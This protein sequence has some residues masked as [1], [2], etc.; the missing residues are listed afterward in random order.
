MA[1]RSSFVDSPLNGAHKYFAEASCAPYQKVIEEVAWR[2]ALRYAQALA[3][4][5]PNNSY[6][7][8]MDL[9]MGNDSRGPLSEALRGMAIDI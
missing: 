9:Y 6:Q 2:D 7:P 4:W 1:N 8:A 3:S 5:Q